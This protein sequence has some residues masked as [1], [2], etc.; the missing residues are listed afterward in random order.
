MPPILD[1]AQSNSNVSSNLFQFGS[2]PSSDFC[3]VRKWLG[4]I[5]VTICVIVS[6]PNIHGSCWGN[7]TCS[8]EIFFPYSRC[9]EY[10]N[11]IP[12]KPPPYSDT[13]EQII[14]IISLRI[15]LPRTTRNVIGLNLHPNVVKQ[16]SIKSLKT[17]MRWVV[18]LWRAWRDTAH[19]VINLRKESSCSG[20]HQSESCMW[21]NGSLI[22]VELK[23]TNN[24]LLISIRF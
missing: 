24:D 5:H 22:N 16:V 11:L 17:L 3:V 7:I 9:C 12:V 20:I 2:S 15:P 21:I 10:S 13:T 23:S 6:I 19:N 4:G 14:A 8:A 1:V 18:D